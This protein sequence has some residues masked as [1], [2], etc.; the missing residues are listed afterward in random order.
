MWT[1]G[2]G[3]FGL[4]HYLGSGAPIVT[5]SFR[6]TE[7]VHELCN[8]VD[9]SLRDLKFNDMTR[10]RARI[11]VEEIAINAIVHSTEDYAD[12]LEAPRELACE[13]PDAQLSFGGSAARFGIAVRDYVGLLTKRR[14]L[15]SL[16]NVV[17]EKKGTWQAGR[18][19]V[20]GRGIYMTRAFAKE[21]Y[22]NVK[23]RE[24]TEV[25]LITDGQQK[26]PDVGRCSLKINEI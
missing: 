17:L 18:P 10:G 3:I 26:V 2:E 4:E 9:Q 20:G 23:H 8:D 24:L 15:E 13:M 11:M 19:A 25:V 22:I 14:V 1:T 7:R 12:P 16:A 21:Y 6:T 5:E